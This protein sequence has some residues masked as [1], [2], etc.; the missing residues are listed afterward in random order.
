VI[1][2]LDRCYL[3]EGIP[4]LLIWGS[5]DA[6]LPVGQGYRAHAAMPGSQ[7]EIFRGAG[8][9]PFHTDPVRFVATI[10]QFLATTR[11]AVW[12][13]EH[14]RQLLLAGAVTDLYPEAPTDE[15]NA[16]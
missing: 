3:A 11:P 1:T 14:W 4:T 6:V 15:R 9:F 10:E 2:L 8:H 13:S 16:T 5:R 12:D 7:L